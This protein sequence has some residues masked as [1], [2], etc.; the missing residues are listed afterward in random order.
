MHDSVGRVK[1]SEASFH[2]KKD[3]LLKHLPPNRIFFASIM[4]ITDTHFILVRATNCIHL[5]AC[6]TLNGKEI[7]S[8]FEQLKYVA[9][10]RHTIIKRQCAMRHA[11]LV[12]ARQIGTSLERTYFCHG[13]NQKDIKINGEKGRN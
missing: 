6:S 3:I 4:L 8:L 7:P 5:M 10:A 9:S 12:P 1:L 13:A 2:A 11:W